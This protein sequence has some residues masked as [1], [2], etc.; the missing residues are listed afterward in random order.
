MS[1]I[2]NLL[3]SLKVVTVADLSAELIQPARA[4]VAK[5]KG[6]LTVTGL[7][8]TDAQL[9][10][11]AVGAVPTLLHDDAAV[12]LDWVDTELGKLEAHAAAN[13]APVST[14]AAGGTGGVA[15]STVVTT[16]AAPAPTPAT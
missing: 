16:G 13:P 3:Q 5:L 10:G 1:D 11:D 4:A 15:G 7:A 6:N 12:F 9:A 2:T 14:V 8:G